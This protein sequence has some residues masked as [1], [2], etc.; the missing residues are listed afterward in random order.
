MT[1]RAYRKGRTDADDLKRRAAGNWRQILSAVTDVPADVLNSAHHPCPK[2]GGTDRFRAL[3]DFA[4]T[5]GT[6]CNQCFTENNGDGLA[7]VMHFGGVNFVTAHPQGGWF[8]RHRASQR[9]RPRH[10][11]RQE[12]RRPGHAD[13]EHQADSQQ[14]TDRGNAV[15]HV[16]QGQTAY[17]GRGYPAMRRNAGRMERLPMR[18]ARRPRADRRARAYRDRALPGRR[19]AVSRRGQGGRAQ[20]AYNQ[21]VR[22]LVAR[23]RRRDDR[24]HDPRRGGRHRPVGGCG[25]DAGRMGC[26]DQHG[27]RKGPR[28]AR[29]PVGRRQEDPR[30]AT[31]PTRPEST[32]N[33]EQ[34]RHTTRP[35]QT[36][37]VA[38]LPYPAE[39]AHGKDLSDYL[40]DGHKISDLPTAAVTAE[41]AAAWSKAKRPEGNG[42][43]IEIGPDESRVVD[44]A[45]AALAPLEN[46]Y[47]RGGNL[48][49]VVEGADA[50]RGIARRKTRRGLRCYAMPA[51]ESYW[52]TPQAGKSSSLMAGGHRSIRRNGPSK[53]LTPVDNGGVSANLWPWLNRRYYA[54]TAR[55]CKRAAM[56]N[57]RGFSFGQRRSFRPPRRSRREPTPWPRSRCCWRWWKISRLQ[58]KPTARHGLP[59]R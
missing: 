54:P 50:P 56:T 7:A 24:N 35:A 9:R 5:G 15:R 47:Q 19:R 23:F 48:V 58:R 34:R 2:C 55:S 40:C 3:D 41:D 46:I 39:K 8:S 45:I 57:R 38:E 36:R 17:H 43:E 42:P 25:Q 13:K 32:A 30:R 53:P 28:Q 29:A 18:P 14:R 12:G 1:T 49:Q 26:R 4:E 37:V 11:Q 20:D 33:I 27:R 22:Q 51:C 44:E 59:A 10:N 31:M 21:G 16:W 52:P 6:I